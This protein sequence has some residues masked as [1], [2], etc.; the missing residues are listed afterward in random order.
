MFQKS[1]AIPYGAKVDAIRKAIIHGQDFY[2]ETAVYG[3]L[4][5]LGIDAD[6]SWV[7]TGTP[8]GARSWAI[9]STEINRWYSEII[10]EN[11]E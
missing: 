4:V 8:H 1:D 9:C 3:K 2:I 5:V 7:R 6:G 10:Q 11:F